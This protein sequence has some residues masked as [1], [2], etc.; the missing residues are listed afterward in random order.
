MRTQWP[1]LAA[2]VDCWW[3]GVERDLAQ[4]RLSPPWRVWARAC[5][6]PHVYGA[7]HVAHTRC[8]QRKAR[9]RQAW[10]MR[11]TTLDHHVLTQRLPPESLEAWQAWAAQRVR[12]LQRTSAAVAGRHGYLA[13]MHHTQRGLPQKRHKVWTVLHNFACR[14]VDGTTPASRFFG[15]KFPDLFETVCPSMTA[16]PR[17]RQRQHDMER[18]R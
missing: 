3:A 18:S 4:A 16:L 8:A 7:H 9:L 11:H 5:L 6:F 13:P 1:A 15:Q 17:P 2:L 12:A 10:A 14:A